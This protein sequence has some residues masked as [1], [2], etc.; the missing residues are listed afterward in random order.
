MIVRPAAEAWAGSRP[1]ANDPR[2]EP[3]RLLMVASR[4]ATVGR[5]RRRAPSV[6][7]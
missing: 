1:A 6:P 7:T 5:Q 4:A 2:R 3:L